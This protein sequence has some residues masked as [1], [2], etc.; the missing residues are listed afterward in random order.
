M[1]NN[2]V[3]A[4]DFGFFSCCTIRLRLIIDFFNQNGELPIVDSS[5]QWSSYKD[6]PPIYS[7]ITH[8]LFNTKYSKL[9]KKKIEFSSLCKGKIFED[10]VEDQFSDY[11]LINFN[12]VNP[13]IDMYF[14]PSDEIIENI[15]FLKIKYSIDPKNIISVLYRGNDKSNEVFVP[16]YDKF[17]KKID[18]SK[19]RL[20]SHKLLIQTDEEDFCNF[21]LS[22]YP[23][24]IVINELERIKKSNTAIHFLTPI[25]KRF[26]LAKNFL[27]V[28][29]IIGKTSNIITNIGNCGMWACLFRGNT[30]NVNIVR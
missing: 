4:H 9:I 29:I 10:E 16:S 1:T 7:D 19:D 12:D 15:N 11:N 21:V 26:N 8:L 24:S 27:S 23:D 22:K 18:E 13:F 28:M 2:L 17:M 30:N 25:G 20:P 14:S 3:V 6:D 5:K